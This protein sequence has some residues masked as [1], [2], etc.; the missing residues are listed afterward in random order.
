MS[1]PDNVPAP[2]SP[3]HFARLDQSLARLLHTQRVAAL[4]TLDAQ[5]EPFVS[6]APYAIE[7]ESA[8][9][10]LCISALA[11]HTAQ[12]QQHPLASLMVM[13]SEP[14]SGEVHALERATLQVQAHFPEPASAPEQ[15]ARRA[16]LGRFAQA[17]LLLQL[18]DF[19]IVTLRSLKL[20]HV[21][22]FGAARSV[23]EELVALL[24]RLPTHLAVS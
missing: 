13:Q 10:V 17:E 2:A 3:V 7:P 23:D 4:G 19:R 5:G 1:E 16:Y 6:M 9:L 11:A 24:L 12:L 8:Q 21:A 15:A 14:A 22:G 20:R 18:P